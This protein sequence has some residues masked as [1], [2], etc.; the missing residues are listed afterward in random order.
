MTAPACLRLTVHLKVLRRNRR[1]MIGKGWWGGV[2]P[3]FVNQLIV[4]RTTVSL[5]VISFTRARISVSGSM[6]PSDTSVTPCFFAGPARLFAQKSWLSGAT[7][8]SRLARSMPLPM[9]TV[10]IRNSTPSAVAATCNV[11]FWVVS[12][13]SRMP[14]GLPMSIHRD[15]SPSSFA[16]IEVGWFASKSISV[17]SSASSLLSVR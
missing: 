10:P 17:A 5:P 15:S 8:T 1:S 13:S 12:S 16:V 7:H 4:W 6:F 9:S 3:V 11:G 2:D 14:P